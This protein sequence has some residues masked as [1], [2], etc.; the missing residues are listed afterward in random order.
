M[1]SR[2]VRKYPQSRKLLTGIAVAGLISGM[3]FVGNAVLASTPASVF[4]LEGNAISATG[5]GGA[6]PDDWDRVC[7]EQSIKDGLSAAAAT[8]QCTANGPTHGATAVAW[9]TDTHAAVGNLADCTGN[10]C[11]IFTGGGSKDPI[12]IN[13]W[14]WKDNVGGLPDKDNLL[15]GFAARYSVAPSS[16][17]VV[18]TT[19]PAGTKCELLLFGND[20][21]DNSGDAQQGFW[22]FQ[23]KIGLG[24]NAIGGGNGFTSSGGTEFHRNGDLLLISDFSNGGAVSTITVYTWD[25]GCTATNIPKS[26]PVSGVS[27]GDANLRYQASSD[28]ANCNPVNP[29]ISGFCGIVNPVDGT[30]T[31]WPF[32]DKTT[33]NATTHPANTYL[34]GEFYEGGVNLSFLNLAGECFA[35]IASETRS[36]QTTSA[37]LKDF[38]L[39]GFGDCTSHVVTTPGNSTGTALTDHN[40]N[41]IPDVS[42][43][44]GS[45]GVRDHA[46]V[47]VSGVTTW[48]GNVAF[49]LCGPLA[50]GSTTNCASGG[51][52]I[53]FTGGLTGAV[54][55]T[56]NTV[57]SGLATLTS[58]GRYCWRATF[59]ATTNGVPSS[60]DP[61]AD[62]LTT[63]SECFEV[64][65]VQ[66]TMTTAA[67]GPV[68]AGGTLSDTA[69]IAGLATQPGTNGIGPGG[70]INA[71]NGAAAGGS[72]TWRALGP[73][74]CTTVAMAATSRTV[75]GNGTYPKTAAPDNQAAVSFTASTAGKYT[76][77]AA[78]TS[79][80]TNN[81]A[82]AESACPDTTHTEEAFVGDSSTV[83]TPQT[84]AGADLTDHNANSVPDVSI[85][86]GSVTVQDHAVVSVT[87]ITPW[88]GSVAFSL[89]GPLA[90]NSTTNCQSGGTSIPFLGGATGAVSNASPAVDSQDTVL[91]S[92]GRYCWRATFTPTTNGVPSSSDPK[93]A[94]STTECFEVLPVRPTLA[95]QASGTVTLGNAISDTATIS[96][97]ATQPGTDGIGDGSINA[98]NGAAAGG[99][100]SWTAFG[101]N[102]CTTT[103]MSATSRAVSGNGTYPKTAAP[104]NQ[105][106]VSFIPTALGTYTFVA[107][108]GGNSPNNLASTPVACADQPS[109]ET[110]EITGVSSLITDQ[111]WLPNDTATLTGDANLNGSLVFTLYNDLTCGTSGGTSKYSE[112][113][114]VT[115]A[116]TG[117]TFGTHNGSVLATTFKAF[118]TGDYSWNVSYDD[119]RLADPSSSC[120]T[121]SLTINNHH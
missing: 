59:T 103:A 50:T 25:T 67:S 60:S 21:Y 92:V 120:E 118:A 41:T 117:S 64:L 55:N 45:V 1:I 14:A 71:T 113:I 19:A 61:K 80:T 110:V 8:A 32:V 3:F 106:A 73:N 69:T 101:P 36:S 17:C 13:S 37:V 52:A 62:D 12:D 95:T 98:T 84:G 96:G 104:D 116:A 72:I 56:S 83:T 99:S 121:T 39:G 81:L 97:L 20:R 10:N 65:P 82:I 109:A 77:V 22:F 26:G 119:S 48:A 76:F 79:P 49:S 78:Y 66:P 15:H 85:G 16:T 30:V 88:A 31:P 90:L 18:P 23:N 108:Y 112:T 70:T 6:A 74:N 11:T 5:N 46:V 29:A 34:Q 75:S 44:S 93:D 91:T 4:E 40:S 100:I 35:S 28:Q 24:S 7:Y 87:G 38:V 105:A 27:C 2:K 94:T 63:V 86:T 33:V 114:T 43:G 111:D 89:C 107:S 68:A 102:N 57:D 115:D 47:T 9:A 58:V 53:P 42:I 54:S 51:V